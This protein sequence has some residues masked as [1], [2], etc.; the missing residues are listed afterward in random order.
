MFE[1]VPVYDGILIRVI[2]A[3]PGEGHGHVLLGIGPADELPAAIVR[4]C[5]TAGVRGLVGDLQR[6]AAVAARD[7]G[8]P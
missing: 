2:A 7:E 8:S 3:G 5:G 1:G 4:L 6:A